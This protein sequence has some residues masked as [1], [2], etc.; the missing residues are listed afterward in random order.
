MTFR[1]HTRFYGTPSKQVPED[2]E[3]CAA[4]ISRHPWHTDQCQRK[5]GHGPAGAYCKQHDPVAVGV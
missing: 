5:R 3:R 4:R 1:K 2:L